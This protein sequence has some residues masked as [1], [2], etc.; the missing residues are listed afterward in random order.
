MGTVAAGECGRQQ[1]AKSLETLIDGGGG[2][3]ASRAMLE[4]DAPPHVVGD[5]ADVEIQDLLKGARD[6][7]VR[8]LP[9]QHD[10]TP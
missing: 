7:G 6:H 1:A 5:D 8:A 2:V 10:Y 3:A 9:K 4:I